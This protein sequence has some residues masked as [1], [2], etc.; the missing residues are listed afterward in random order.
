MNDFMNSLGNSLYDS[1]SSLDISVHNKIKNTPVDSF[2][3]E[4]KDYLFKSDSVYKLSQLP[5]DTYLD[6]N[7][8]E[9][10]YVQCY[11][12][13]TEYPVPNEMICREE[14]E[15]AVNVGNL[16]LQLQDDGL[17]HIIN[18]PKKS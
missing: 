5:Q 16:K 18:V 1:L 11:L 8:F 13:H 6:I 12:E 17:Y 3:H 15:N 14:L 9:E 2:I 4:L 7:E 10:N